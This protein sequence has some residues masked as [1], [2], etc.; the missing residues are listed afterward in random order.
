MVLAFCSGV[1][2]SWSLSLASFDQTAI[3]KKPRNDNIE[4][5][6]VIA[7][8]RSGCLHFPPIY[9]IKARNRFAGTRK[10]LITAVGS[11]VKLLSCRS[12]MWARILLN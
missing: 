9:E 3:L 12:G 6:S 5:K 1:W 8:A 10:D 11:A 7:Q 4:H 2:V